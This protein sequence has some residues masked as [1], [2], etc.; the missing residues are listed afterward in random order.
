MSS[1]LQLSWEHCRAITAHHTSVHVLLGACDGPKAFYRATAFQ[2]MLP[3]T[4]V[5]VVLPL[6][7][8][9]YFPLFFFLYLQ[10][11]TKHPAASRRSISFPSH[12]RHR[13]K[14]RSRVL[15]QQGTA[16]H[17]V[18]LDPTKRSCGALQTQQA[19]MGPGG[20][21]L[22]RCCTSWKCCL[23]QSSAG[24]HQ[25]HPLLGMPSSPCT[26]FWSRGEAPHLYAM[27]K[28]ASAIKLNSNYCISHISNFYHANINC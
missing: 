18:L 23:A 21:A 2:T 13:W 19:G 1:C 22:H 4:V 24:L 16:E 15:L 20:A 25:P 11:H 14:R 27:C 6:Q 12:L 10:L 26:F 7:N 8:S 5:H 9:L 17:R 3:P 28:S